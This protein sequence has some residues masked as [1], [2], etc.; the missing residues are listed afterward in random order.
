[1]INQKGNSHISGAG[2][3]LPEKIVYSE[4]L[5]REVKSQDVGVRYDF[6]ERLTG[7]KERRV[8]TPKE[9]YAILAYEAAKR[10][11]ADAGI[12]PT[13]I[14][15]VIFCG[16]DSDY[17][18]PSTAHEI[19]RM[20][21]AHNAACLDISN[22]CLG[23]LNG[24]SIA[25]LYIGSGAAENILICTGEKPSEVSFDVVNQLKANRSKENLR[26][27]LGAFTVGDA[28][29][30]FVITKSGG[31]P[32][33]NHMR[34][35]T[36]SLLSDLCYYKRQE[37]FIE[38]EMNMETISRAMIIEHEKLMGDTY[39]SLGWRPEDVDS[40][41]C[42]Q[43]GAKPHRQMA[44]MANVPINKAPITYDRF[45]NLTSATFAVNYDSNRPQ[46]NEKI[47]F[48]GAG[49]GCSICQIGL[50]YGAIPRTH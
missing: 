18:E 49:S 13:D 16:I 8:S 50:D 4:E 2:S 38:F 22:A 39:A 43:V 6:L 41:Y 28:G 9:T 12:Q 20:L 48:L 35:K 19:Q 21:G 31:G 3:Y 11:I 36:N 29:G 30:A 32:R 37:G 34:F 47:L 23:L 33:L 15:G 40:L 5:M 17:P 42:H 14:D 26:R 10:A 44:L 1:M 45:G 24:V 27:L 7:I 25:D 46:K